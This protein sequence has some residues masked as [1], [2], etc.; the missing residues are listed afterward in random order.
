MFVISVMHK[1]PLRKLTFTMNVAFSKNAEPL[2]R[3]RGWRY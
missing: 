1:R 3:R 2:N